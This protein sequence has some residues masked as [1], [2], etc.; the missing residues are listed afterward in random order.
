MMGPEALMVRRAIWAAIMLAAAGWTASADE[1]VL[2]NGS[3]LEGVVRE[4][5]DRVTVE[6]ASGTLTLPKSEVR[7]IRRDEEQIREYEKR[8]ESARTAEDFYQLGLWAQE[9]KSAPRA[10][11]AFKRAIA[12][13]ANHEGARGQLGY[14]RHEGRW[15]R[16]DE[17][18]VAK[19][20]VWHRG[21]W[22]S[23]EA[24]KAILEAESQERMLSDRLRAAEE[25]ARLRAMLEL[26]RRAREAERAR[27]PEGAASGTTFLPWYYFRPI[28]LQAD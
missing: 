22:I 23:R 13:D 6:V 18:M 24:H 28:P 17:L 8:K 3:T 7:E 20:F 19:G 12:L 1:V 9:R 10:E 16:G 5:G 4:D 27:P 26:D 21:S 2:K 15:L 25:L 14:E 11:Q